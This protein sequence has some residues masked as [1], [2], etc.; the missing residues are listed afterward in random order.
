MLGEPRGRAGERQ[1]QRQRHTGKHSWRARQRPRRVN[2][3]AMPAPLRPGTGGR[4]PVAALRVRPLCQ[5]ATPT[6]LP[7]ATG[8]GP[9]RAPRRRPPPPAGPQRRSAPPRSPPRAGTA[10][11]FPPASCRHRHCSLGVC[12]FPGPRCPAPG[13]T[14]LP[15]SAGHREGSAPSGGAHSQASGRG[16]CAP[17][18]GGAPLSLIAAP[19]RPC[20][21][22]IAPGWPPRGLPPQRSSRTGHCPH[23]DKYS[24]C[25][26]PRLRLRSW[27]LPVPPEQPAGSSQPSATAGQAQVTCTVPQSEGRLGHRQG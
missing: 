2:A 23:G 12:P 20:G 3:R 6:H 11:S 13:G 19:A 24:P 26:F 27:Q 16:R 21:A 10:G 18:T 7:R 8:L 5:P 14:D 25:L 22:A 1:G 17:P 4:G 15:R 9:L